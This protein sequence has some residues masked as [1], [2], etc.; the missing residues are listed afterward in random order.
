MKHPLII[1]KIKLN[2]NFGP[3]MKTWPLKIKGKYKKNR[4]A[5]YLLKKLWI[6]KYVLVSK[7]Q[8]SGWLYLKGDKHHPYCIFFKEMLSRLCVF[9]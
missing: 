2:L 3:N 9:L 6:L 8:A 7:T 1:L 5:T 4:S